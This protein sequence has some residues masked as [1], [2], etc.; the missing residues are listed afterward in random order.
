MSFPGVKLKKHTD[1]VY[2]DFGLFFNLTLNARK[3]HEIH[4]QC[5]FLIVYIQSKIHLFMIFIKTS[6][7]RAD[8]HPLK[9]SEFSLV[10]SHK[11]SENR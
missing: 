3:N 7:F 6:N 8:N 4:I 5:E 11:R 9:F 10:I 1:R 2:V